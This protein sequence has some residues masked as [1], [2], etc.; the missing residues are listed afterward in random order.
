M[1]GKHTAFVLAAGFGTRL[2]PLT[3]VVPK[4]LVPVCGVPM[5]SYALALCHAHGHRHVLLNGHYLAEQLEPWSGE[6]EGVHVTLSIE[7]PDILGTGGGLGHVRDQLAERF[8]IVNADILCDVDLAKLVERVP[9]GGATMALRP[10]DDVAIYG[11]VAADET[12][13]VVQ[14]VA[15]ASAEP[16]GH[17]ARDTHFSGIHAMHIDAL[18]QVPDAFSSI[19]TD[20][21]AHTVPK[22]LVRSVRHTGTWLDVGNP[23]AYLDANLQVLRGG[24]ELPFDPIERAAFAQRSSV[25]TGDSSL[26][27]GVSVSGAVWVGVGAVIGDGAV[28]HDC[29]VGAGAV[30]AAGVTLRNA[31]V[32]DGCE[33]QD[34]VMGGIVI[35]TG[36]VITPD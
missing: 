22:R 1:A 34:D 18:E 9:E 10:S 6:H 7:S 5:L 16:H 3:E 20:S 26:V 19:I 27:D 36:R 15:V 21:Y 29:I 32:W 8:A 13:T 23:A 33:V 4:P 11:V 35:E 30:V 14:L 28:L 17:V 25:V 31:V 2:R 24:V 12:D